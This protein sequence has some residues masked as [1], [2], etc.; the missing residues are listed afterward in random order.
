MNASD[1]GTTEGVGE[2]AQTS[3]QQM[4]TEQKTQENEAELEEQ[5]RLR[6]ELPKSSPIEI[7]S[8]ATI[9]KQ[10]KKGY[11]QVKYLWE[12]NGY[13]MESR[14][15]T[16]TPNAPPEQGNT[17]VVTRRRPGIGAGK[18]ARPN[19]TEVLVGP[20]GKE[21]W[22]DQKVWNKAICDQKAG[23]AT[24]EQKEMLKNGHWKA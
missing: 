4:E 16:R 11:H 18:N 6:E 21:H 3:L 23:E 14:W 13:R 2:G 10:E 20:K 7:P 1:N 22:V 19:K 24:E 9:K 8:N 12:E 5:I 15:H 17:W